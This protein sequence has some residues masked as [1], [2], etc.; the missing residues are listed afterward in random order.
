MVNRVDETSEIRLRRLDRD[1][2]IILVQGTAPTFASNA[3][4]LSYTVQL[5][6]A[7]R[8]KLEREKKPVRSSTA[9]VNLATGVSTVV[10][11]STSHRFSPDGR[12]LAT[13]L[14]P[15]DAAKRDAADLLVRDLAA[16]TTQV[17]GNVATWAWSEAGPLLAMVL[18]TDGA[19]GN[20]VQLLDAGTG[21][22]ATLA[23]S[24]DRYRG[25]AWRRG[26]GDLAVLR[27]Q[28]TAAW[29]DTNHV[30]HAWRGLGAATTASVNLDPGATSAV[31]ST[32]R[33]SEGR[34]PEWSRDGAYLVIGLR[35][36]EPRVDSARRGADAPKPSDV[37]VWH[38]R[39]VRPI[40]MQKVQDA[41]DVRRT[42]TAIW[43]PAEGRVVPA[44][45]GLLDQVT[46]A[47]QGPVA[48][49]ITQTRYAW[50]Q[51][52]GRQRRDV[53][54]IDLRTGV[55]RRLAD[56][57]RF[58]GT[59]SP[60]GRLFAFFSNGTWRVANTATGAVTNVTAAGAVLQ[61]RDTDSPTDEFGP[62]GF[63]GWSA[64]ERWIFVYDE[65]DVWRLPT[66]GRPGTR[67]TSG[68]ADRVVHRLVSLEPFDRRGLG[69]D[70]TKPIYLTLNG[71][72]SKSQA[73]RG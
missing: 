37:Q 4:W 57:V 8:E 70:V 11:Q 39:D 41:Q 10:A 45:T 35:A 27:S 67:V 28:V 44:Q 5:T 18:E 17:I 62:F 61:D 59:L 13:R 73:L 30:V 50:G 31:P 12:F 20:G 52:F 7:E 66:D 54:A 42:I 21:R 33:I 22:L 43:W 69:F 68:A 36:R 63:G 60:T 48:V 51:M 46:L 15:A 6:P 65:Y 55:R 9:F 64:D 58:L 47:E 32:M 19:A 2:T 53:E 34:A 14:H 25:L 23:S 72:W 3:R 38:A 29:K 26:A 16:G 24:S 40:P 49:E 71:E 1:T 56:S